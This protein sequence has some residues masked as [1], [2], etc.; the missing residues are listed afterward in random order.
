MGSWGESS[1]FCGSAIGEKCDIEESIG[2]ENQVSGAGNNFFTQN[3]KCVTLFEEGGRVA[4]L[5]CGQEGGCYHHSLMIMKNRYCLAS[6]HR[7]NQIVHALP[8]L[9]H[10]C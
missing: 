4:D 3:N 2:I 6:L 1:Q 10:I 8:L 5:L 7:A 9:Y